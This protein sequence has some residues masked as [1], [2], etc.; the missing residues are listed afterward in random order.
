MPQKRQCALPKLRQLRVGAFAAEQVP[1]KLS[2]KL[3]D[4][5]RQRWLGDITFLGGPREIKRPGDRQEVA[6]LVHLHRSR[7]TR[8]GNTTAA[9]NERQG[10]CPF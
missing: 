7:P 10:T 2:L 8:N 4:G 3:P 5:A 1:A 6:N 9:P